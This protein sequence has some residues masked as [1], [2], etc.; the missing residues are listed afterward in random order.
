[1]TTRKI[2]SSLHPIRLFPNYRHIFAL[3]SSQCPQCMTRTIHLKKWAKYICQCGR[4]SDPKLRWRLD[5]V[6]LCR[7]RVSL[8]FSDCGQTFW[9]YKRSIV[10]NW[11]LIWRLLTR[12][13]HWRRLWLQVFHCIASSIAAN[14]R[15][16]RRG[17]CQILSSRC[18][19]TSACWEHRK[20]A[21]L[22]LWR[23]KDRRKST[24][25]RTK[26][27]GAKYWRTDWSIKKGQIFSG[28]EW[29]KTWCLNRHTKESSFVN[30]VELMCVF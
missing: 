13:L 8:V 12:N 7:H 11:Q 22:K 18:R 15:Q 26:A 28:G 17:R 10:S 14:L 30:S 23:R 9:H 2:K 20:L 27:S 5:I 24:D 1:M 3:T 25:K 4:N 16:T 6:N 19:N 29:N 21:Q